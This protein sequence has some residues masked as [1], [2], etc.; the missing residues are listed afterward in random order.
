MYS[1]YG[2]HLGEDICV[3]FQCCLFKKDSDLSSCIEEF[4]SMHWTTQDKAAWRKRLYR[5]VNGVWFIFRL[6]PKKIEG[7]FWISAFFK[8]KYDRSKGGF[9]L[10][11]S[12]GTAIRKN[13]NKVN[14]LCMASLSILFAA[15]NLQEHIKY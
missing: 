9:H 10:R 1:A 3:S 12:T 15:S 14:V 13:L 4:L 7:Q 8:G 5:N 11:L 2:L 6:Q